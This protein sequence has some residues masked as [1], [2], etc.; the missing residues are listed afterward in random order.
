MNRT[1]ICKTSQN[2]DI[3]LQELDT[4]VNGGGYA[5]H[6]NGRLFKTGLFL[7]EALDIFN[8]L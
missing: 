8:S 3:S 6:I 4:P 1:F 5:V 7:D 2:G